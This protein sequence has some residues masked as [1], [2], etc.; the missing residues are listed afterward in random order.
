MLCRDL[1]HCTPRELDAQPATAILDHLAVLSAEHRHHE[2]ERR[3]AER[4]S[5]RRR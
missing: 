1:Y 3:K 4:Q 5:K 2:M